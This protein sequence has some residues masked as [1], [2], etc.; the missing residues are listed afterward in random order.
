MIFTRIVLHKKLL[1]KVL[2]IL[3]NLYNCYE[4]EK[5]VFYK[6]DIL[7]L[8]TYARKQCLYKVL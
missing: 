5:S 3:L 2:K 6:Q 1:P 7:K 8:K 4:Y